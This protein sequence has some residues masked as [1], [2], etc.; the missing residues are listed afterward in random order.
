[1]KLTELFT[2][3]ALGELANSSYVELNQLELNKNQLHRVINAINQGL[4]LIH[5]HLP[6]RHNQ[7]VIQ[8]HDNI[9]TY[10]LD[11]RYAQSNTNSTAAIKFIMDTAFNPFKDDILNILG[12]FN[13]EGQQ[14][15]LNDQYAIG[16]LFTP[17]YNSLMIPLAMWKNHKVP[18]NIVDKL[19][20]V[21]QADHPK[22]P[23]NEPLSSQ[24][25]IHLSPIYQSMLQAYVDHLLHMHIGSEQSINQSNQYFA[26][27]NSLKQ[28]AKEQ[29]IGVITQTGV[30]IK[31]ILRE[32]I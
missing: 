29:G 6:L 15:P 21:Y 28:T 14:Y 25:E 5:T 32:F 9:G 16:S 18:Y 19:V 1:M 13:L 23:L 26:K 4:T 8:I 27:F 3:L 24:M 17:D 30:N 12:V 7:I 22:I 10:Y 20:I 11:S 2:S 31:P